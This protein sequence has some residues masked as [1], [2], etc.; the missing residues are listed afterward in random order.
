MHGARRALVPSAYTARSMLSAV[1]CSAP[2]LCVRAN[3]PLPCAWR[4]KH[5]ARCNAGH[6]SESVVYLARHRSTG[7]FVAIKC[8]E[9]FVENDREQLDH[10]TVRTPSAQIRTLRPGGRMLKRG[11]TRRTYDRLQQQV[12]FW[13]SLQHPSILPLY[14]AFVDQERLWEVLPLMSA[15]SSFFLLF[16]PLYRAS[17]HAPLTRRTPRSRRV[18]LQGRCS[19][20]SQTFSR[21]GSSRASSRPSSAKYCT[22]SCTCTTATL[23]TGPCTAAGPTT[24]PP[25]QHHT[26]SQHPRPAHPH[27]PTRTPPGPAPAPAP[28]PT[29][30]H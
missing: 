29:P 20:C 24:P 3:S 21:T 15:G 6:G 18:R 22:P 17:A 10:V 25:H 27:P 30:F 11:P 9:L 28:P 7:M 4:S 23:F 26:H 2:I 8:V 14:L 12:C 13:K 16:L 5:R 19:A 1:E